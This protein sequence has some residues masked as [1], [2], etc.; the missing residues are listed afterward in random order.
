MASYSDIAHRWANQD[1]GRNGELK[2]S[3]CHCDEKNYYSYSTV[4]AQWLDKDKKVMAIIDL[5]LS[6]STASHVNAISSA[7]REDTHIF[8][9][10]LVPGWRSGW[11]NAELLNNSESFDKEK[12]MYL[13]NKFI[14]DL[15]KEFEYIT[16]SKDLKGG[17]LDLHWWNEIIRLNSLYNNDASPKKWLSQKL[18]SCLSP[19]NRKIV[20]QKRK[21]VRALLEKKEPKEIVDIMFGKG[22]YQ[23]WFDRTKSL[24]KAAHSREYAIKVCNFFGAVHGWGR[25]PLFSYKDLKSMPISRLIEIK[26]ANYWESQDSYIKRQA[27]SGNAM[28]RA[29]SFIGLCD[30]ENYYNGRY[31]TVVN[32]FTGEIVYKMKKDP[33]DWRDN[34]YVDFKESDFKEF[35][36]S[37]DKFQWLRRFYRICEIKNRRIIGFELSNEIKRGRL[38][39]TLSPEETHIYNEWVDRHERYKQNEAKEQRIR[40]E[41]QAA[42]KA[43]RLE[44]ERLEREERLSKLSEYQLN[45][46]EGLRNIWRDNF[47]NIPNECQNDPEYFYGGNVL[48]RMRDTNTVETSKNIKLSV[49]KCKKY[50]S[51]IQIWHNHPERFHPVEINT[52]NCGS[53]RID[54]FSNDMLVSGCH[55]IAYCEMERVAQQ[56]G[57]IK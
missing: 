27:H 13:V 38:L 24:R 29:I 4:I 47:G 12:R 9:F 52:E 40:E 51:I 33:L 46:I 57:F 25:K 43:A 56:L 21:M 20:M 22:V 41:R 2:A 36:K 7:V 48:I 53:Y 45:G 19:K 31:K 23:A 18:N 26:H 54:S 34:I 11:N 30:Q 14:D 10:H 15:Y 6:N 42:D 3:N 5:S 35:C 55:R 8:R 50:W 16:E 28:K 44:K 37:P 39:E 17:E 1:F 49:S 32:H